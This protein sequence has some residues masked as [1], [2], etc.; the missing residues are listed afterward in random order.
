M[1]P[2]EQ[3]RLERFRA[4]R[5]INLVPHQGRAK[6]CSRIREFLDTGDLPPQQLLFAQEY[7]VDLNATQAAI[8]AGYSVKSASC[9]GGELLQK[10]EI[11]R[12]IRG[13]MD[14][15]CA[16]TQI[17][18]DRVLQELARIGFADPK[19]L[20]DQD[21]DLIPVADLPEDL[22]H[23][24]L[25]MK[26]H[27]EKTSSRRDQGERAGDSEE[28]TVAYVKHVKLNPKIPALEKLA[29]HVGVCQT[30]FQMDINSVHQHQHQINI[31]DLS[32]D[33]LRVILKLAGADYVSEEETWAP[34]Q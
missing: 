17:T 31:S 7:I 8:R 18:A 13:A 22:R 15:R 23:A 33:E 30:K 32:D 10:P 27:V 26:V 5:E 14:A 4:N 3:A 1:S 25:E 21:G 24:I 20:Y 12:A 9:I 28:T 29:Q 34:R 2:R 11:A 6:A 16:R 19:D